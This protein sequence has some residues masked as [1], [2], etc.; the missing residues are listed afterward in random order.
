MKEDIDRVVTPDSGSRQ[1]VIEGKRGVEDGTAADG[2]PSMRGIE[3]TQAQGM[4]ERGVVQD[5]SHVV[6]DE[7]PAEPVRET[8]D[9]RRDQEGGNDGGPSGGGCRDGS[10]GLH[11]SDLATTSLTMQ[12]RPT[13]AGMIPGEAPS[14]FP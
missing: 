3:H 13:Q 2:E 14:A 4:Q 5:R 7:H 10:G 9:D 8:R 6:Q 1:R 12:R 11:R